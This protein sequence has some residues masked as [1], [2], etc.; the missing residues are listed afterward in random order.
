MVVEI[1]H[2][3]QLLLLSALLVIAASP[4]RAQSDSIG[5]QSPSR[6]IS[7]LVFPDGAQSAIRCDIAAMETKPKRPANCDLEYGQAFM[8]HA[9][10]SDAERICYGDALSDK[11][12]PVVAYGEVWQHRGFTCTV[13]QV[14]VTCSNADRHGFSL[15]R[16]KQE[17]F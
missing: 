11:P 1:E 8:M 7:C 6:N 12:L 16:A 3:R 17:L 5:F 15:S 4:A 9:R 14:G 13:E 10:G 2:M